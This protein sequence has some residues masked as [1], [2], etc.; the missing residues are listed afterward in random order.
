LTARVSRPAGLIA[1]NITD[2]VPITNTFLRD[3][4]G[5]FLTIGGRKGMIDF[6]EVGINEVVLTLRDTNMEAV[7]RDFGD[8]KPDEDPVI[9][10]YE[11]FLK[12]YDSEKKI[13]R[14]VF[15]TPKPVVSYIVRGVHEL[16][17]T[18]F[19]LVDGLADITTWGE[20]VKMHKGLQIP[21]GVAANT[22]FV[23]ILDPA[24]G[25]GTFLVEIIHVIYR[26]LFEKWKL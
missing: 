13:K 10:F 24:T 22:A 19:G 20:L 5:T 26:T 25:T 3:L 14:G 9:F 7:L 15:Y 1:E 8:R 4:L 12:A 6:D 2:M 21:K 17:Q 18:D 11:D 16:L 23:Q